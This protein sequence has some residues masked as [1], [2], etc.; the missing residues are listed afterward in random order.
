MTRLARRYDCYGWE[1]NAG[2]GTPFHRRAL[3][4]RGLTPHHRRRFCIEEQMAFLL[5]ADPVAEPLADVAAECTSAEVGE[6]I[7][8]LHP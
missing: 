7:I 6:P 4:E 2:Y 3:V 1:R 8:Q 5:T